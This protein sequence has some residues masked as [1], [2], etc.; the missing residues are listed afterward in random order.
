MYIVKRGKLTVVADSYKTVFAT[1]SDGT[2][3]GE[4]SMLN[5]ADNKNSNH[6]TANI[7]SVGYTDL[8]VLSKDDLWEYL[9]DYPEARAVLIE[10]GR[11]MLRKDNLLD[12]DVARKQDFEQESTE[13]KVN[14]LEMGLDTIC[15]RFARLLGD[16]NSMQLK[17]KQRVSKLEKRVLTEPG[18]TPDGD[19]N[20]DA[21]ETKNGKDCGKSSS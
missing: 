20:M 2:V 9:A 3:F 5:I 11:Q 6:R 19:G 17:L 16:F 8:F 12:E 10:K 7:R 18:D 14:R 1:L 13:Q 15:T 21:K 4:I